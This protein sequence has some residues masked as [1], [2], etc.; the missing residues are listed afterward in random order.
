MK[1]S[2][3]VKILKKNDCFFVEHGKEHDKWHVTP[4]AGVW[5]EISEN[6]DIKNSTPSLPSR[7]CGL[8]LPCLINLSAAIWSLPSRECGL[9]SRY[10]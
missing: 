5:I 1:T 2:E 10:S 9:K 6:A 3:L 8:K 7:E 4:F